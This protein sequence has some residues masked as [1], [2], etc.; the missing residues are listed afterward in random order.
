M[1]WI[2]MLVAVL[3]LQLMLAGNRS[4]QASLCSHHLASRLLFTPHEVLI[5]SV[6]TPNLHS[7]GEGRM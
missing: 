2:Q 1:L 7:D 3:Q 5:S 6:V 4:H